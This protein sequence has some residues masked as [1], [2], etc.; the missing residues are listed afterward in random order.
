MEDSSSG[1]KDERRSRRL[2]GEMVLDLDTNFPM[3]EKLE[4]VRKLPTN[5]GVYGRMM[6]LCSGGKRNMSVQHASSEVAKE[7]FCKH[8]HDT[9]FCLSVRQIQRKIEA[10]YQALKLG[11]KRINQ[12]RESGPDVRKLKEMVEKKESLFE[13]FLDPV[14]DKEKIKSCEGEWG[15]KMSEAEFR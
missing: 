9:V 8:Y 15:V 2:S 5:K 1:D 13:V 6:S 14:K 4:P 10:G 3:C 12:G 11:Q 7:V